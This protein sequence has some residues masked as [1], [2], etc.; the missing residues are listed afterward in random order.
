MIINY[1]LFTSKA[2]GSKRT[3]EILLKLKVRKRPWKCW[4]AALFKETSDNTCGEAPI[5]VNKIPQGCLKI[6]PAIVLFSDVNPWIVDKCICFFF[7]FFPCWI[8]R[9]LR[10]GYP[11]GIPLCPP[12]IF[13]VTF[14][15]LS[16]IF[17]YPVAD[18]EGACAPP[19]IRKAYIIQ[20]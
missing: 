14:V 1:Y 3:F 5:G 20:R 6:V 19:K 12:P 10:T 13:M 18:L 9:Y 7:L 15:C 8:H 11:F 16:H 2:N 4:I 17:T